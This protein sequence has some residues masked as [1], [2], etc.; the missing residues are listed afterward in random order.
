MN[1]AINFTGIDQLVNLFNTRKEIVEEAKN[2]AVDAA[3]QRF[4]D[5]MYSYATAGHPDNPNVITGDM[6]GSV[7]WDHVGDGVAEAGIINSH[8]YAF[9]VEFGHAQEPGRY[10]PAIGKRLVQSFVPAYPFF[11]PTL[12]Q[13]I[14]GGEAIDIITS[15]MR[16]AVS[17]GD[18]GGAVSG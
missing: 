1:I 17:N 8:P 4:R 14:D 13:V 16:N 18:A 11:R 12:T 15:V 9:F 7:T 2:N 5:V 10:V 6:S 3:A